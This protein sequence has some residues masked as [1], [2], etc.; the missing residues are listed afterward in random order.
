MGDP[1]C[2]AFWNSFSCWAMLLVILL[3]ADIPPLDIDVGMLEGGIAFRSISTST[4]LRNLLRSS[5]DAALE[6]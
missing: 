3:L 2:T 6:M 5:S 1:G 4:Y